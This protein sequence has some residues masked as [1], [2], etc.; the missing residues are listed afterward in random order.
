MEYNNVELFLYIDSNWVQVEINSNIPFPVTMNIADIK[1]ISKRNTTFSKTI[2][3]PGTKANND[4]F[5]YIFDIA[6]FSR[7]NANKKVKCTIVVDTIPVIQEAFF[8]LTDIK[9]DD[10]IHFVYEC[11]IFGDTDSIIKEMGNKLLTDMSCPELNHTYNQ[12][13]IVNSWDANYTNGYYYPLVDY[14]YNWDSTKLLTGPTAGARIEEMRTAVYAKYLWNKIFSESGWSYE[15]N[16]INATSSIWNDMIILGGTELKQIATF[17]YYNSFR[18]QMNANKIL[19]SIG[20]QIFNTGPGGGYKGVISMGVTTSL[21]VKGEDNPSLPGFYT[22]RLPMVNDATYPNGDPSNLWNTSLY[23]YTHPSGYDMDVSLGISLTITLPSTAS[24]HSTYSIPP[25][26]SLDYVASSILWDVYLYRSTSFSSGVYKP[27]N[28][29]VID[30]FSINGGWPLAEFTISPSYQRRT[31]Q[32]YNYLTP[33]ST[34]TKQFNTPLFNQLSGPWA[35]LQPNEK[36]WYKVVAREYY[37]QYNTSVN[38]F[39]VGPSFSYTISSDSFVYNYVSSKPINNQPLSGSSMMPKNFKQIDFFT[40]MVKMFNLYIEPDKT[41]PKRL[42]IEPRDVYYNTGSEKDWTDKVDLNKQ[43]KQQIIAESQAKELLLTYKQDKDAY[44]D[45]Y[46]NNTKE[47]YGEQKY[48][49]DNDFI[50][51]TNKIEVSFAPTPIAAL[52]GGNSLSPDVI[53]LPV[54]SKNDNGLLKPTEFIP[55]ILFKKK[56]TLSDTSNYW[57]LNGTTYSVYPYAGHF[58]D[59]MNGSM[60]LNFGQT[61][62]LYYNLNFITSNNLFTSFYRKQFEELTDKD[63]RIVTLY[64]RLTPQD[65]NDFSFRDR[66]YLDGISSGTNVTYRVNK[67]EYD[68]TIKNTFKVELLKAKD[69]PNRLYTPTFTLSS[70]VDDPSNA[71]VMLGNMTRNTSYSPDAIINGTDNFIGAGSRNVNLY[72]DSNSIDGNNTNINLYGDS[73]RVRGN[74]TDVFA[75]GDN[76]DITENGIYFS[77]QPVINIDWIDAGTDM[78]L[79][80]YSNTSIINYIDA[81]LDT[82]R[83]LGSQTTTSLIDAKTDKI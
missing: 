5:Y 60:D 43:I 74:V 19:N 24:V 30:T 12:T 22:E 32:G 14:G 54:I 11:V 45:N 10:N 9:T 76:M 69:I 3:I 48:I 61:D 83:P 44:N 79:N 20:Y 70:P 25:N 53:K 7:Y 6:N 82:I 68:P 58:N 80:P 21:N 2:E 66:I 64:M 71:R 39:V 77:S 52:Q 26:S 31:S 13:N 15:S 59:P 29:N 50:K 40:S 63:S 47:V 33:G 1:D 51:G 36:V 8:Q 41:I 57:K 27:I 72:G 78:I 75:I 42:K 17:S 56:I 49:V 67:I 18:S 23:E 46:F 62:F 35:R 34:I 55:R 4:V 37:F 38:S 28:L 81:G 73:N 65:I 16:Y